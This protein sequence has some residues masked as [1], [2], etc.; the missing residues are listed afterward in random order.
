MDPLSDGR[1]RERAR[2]IW[3]REGRPEGRAD[4][5]WRLARLELASEAP[6]PDAT[7]PNPIAEGRE[8]DPRG[9]PVEPLLAVENQ[10][11]FPVIADQDEKQP[12]PKPRRKPKR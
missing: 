9:Q 1:I 10:G 4:D 2:R 5:H 12:Y 8:A 11:S 3:E 7:E 6:P